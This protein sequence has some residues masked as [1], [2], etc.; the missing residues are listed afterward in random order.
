MPGGL[1][2]CSRREDE[3]DEWD[4]WRVLREPEIVIVALFSKASSNRGA[5]FLD[6]GSFIGN[7]LGRTYVADEL[8]YCCFIEKVV[9]AGWIE[10]RYIRDILSPSPTN[11][12]LLGRRR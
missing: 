12:R 9:S 2:V 7:G 11:L 3:W 10:L 1:F 5:L 4:E 6:D 8:L